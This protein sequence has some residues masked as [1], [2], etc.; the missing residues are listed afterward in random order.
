M[1]LIVCYVDL[2]LLRLLFLCCLWVYFDFD[3]LGVCIDCGF[4]VSY[5]L[6]VS[7]FGMVWVFC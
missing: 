2:I 7:G 4:S 6:V 5:C 3:C 1:G